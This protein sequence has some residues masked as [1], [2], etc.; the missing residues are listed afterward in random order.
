MLCGSYSAVSS[1]Y[2]L[3]CVAVYIMTTMQIRSVLSWVFAQQ[4]ILEN[5][6]A[7]YFTNLRFNAL[8][9][10]AIDVSVIKCKLYTRVIVRLHY[11]LLPVSGSFMLV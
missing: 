5:Q 10:S 4:R 6:S 2:A 7:D 11:Y 9:I 1:Y 8:R 3:F